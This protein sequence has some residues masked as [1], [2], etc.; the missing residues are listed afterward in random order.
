MGFNFSG[1]S[2]KIVGVKDITIKVNSDTNPLIVLANKIDWLNLADLVLPDLKK[3][4]AKLCWWRGRKLELRIHLAVYILQ[5]M[6]DYKDRQ[7][8]ELIKANAVYQVFCGET[9]IKKWHCPDHTKIEDFRS[10][11]SP[12]TQKVIANE[13]AKLGV[14]LGFV[15]PKEADCDS[16][17]QEANI[18]YPSDV[19]LMV[20]LVALARKV[21]DYMNKN[22]PC[23]KLNPLNID[24][25]NVKSI[26]RKYFFSDYKKNTEEQ[27]LILVGV[28]RAAY[29]NVCEVTR[30]TKVLLNPK[31]EYIPWNIKNAASTLH[32]HSSKYFLNVIPFIFNHIAVKDKLLSLHASKVAFFNKGK[33]SKKK[34]VGRV[35]QLGRIKGNLMFVCKC[36]SVQMPDKKSLTNLIETHQSLFG[37]GTL[38]SVSFDKGY[39]S[40]NND[41]TLVKNNLSP[42]GLQKPGGRK[43]LTSTELD[44]ELN[45][46]NRRAGVEPLIGHVKQGGQLDRSR[47][48]SDDTTESAGYAAVTGFNFRQILRYLSLEM[49]PA[50]G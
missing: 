16:T 22:I 47:M 4:T 3:T 18:A 20:Q 30:Y 50:N 27:F 46:A 48:K 44:L 7:T 24:Y 5:K 31:R 49:K 25:K 28:W 21:A 40:L 19:N 23:F 41:K 34:Q 35:F 6:Y 38:R 32:E 8:E 12:G 14:K 17:I 1:I 2:S 42:L 36:T 39:Y 26:A 15:D 37:A 11:L 33:L 43:A 13:T 29:K 10:R 9:N 45:L